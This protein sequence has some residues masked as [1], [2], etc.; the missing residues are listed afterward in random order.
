MIALL[1]PSSSRLRPR[2]RAT[3]SATVR[4]TSV[5]PVK[6]IRATRLSSTNCR[7]SSVP[8]SLIRK[9]RSGK[10]ASASAAL[11]IFWV[12]MAVSGVLLDGFQMQMSPQIAARKAFHDHT[13][14]GKL[15]ALM[16]PT[17]PIG[18]Y[19]S[20]MRWPGRSECMV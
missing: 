8:A 10:P 3:R 14:T 15:N 20:Y 19:C 9:N 6:L 5:E 4:P 2:R 18:W 13:A 17:S 7:A 11:Q 16:I 12:A 1:P